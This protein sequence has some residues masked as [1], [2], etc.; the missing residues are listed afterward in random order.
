MSRIYRIVAE[1]RHGDN[2]VWYRQCP[3]CLRMSS[4]TTCRHCG[5]VFFVRGSVWYAA[6]DGD[7]ARAA[8]LWAKAKAEKEKT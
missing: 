6:I 7:K 4:A 2:D 5:A 3:F 1:E 8:E